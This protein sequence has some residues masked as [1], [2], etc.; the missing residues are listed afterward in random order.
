M[1]IKFTCSK[2]RNSDEL[3][4]LHYTRKMAEDFIGL[5]TGTSP[6][7]LVPPGPES[8]LGKSVCCRAQLEGEIVDAVPEPVPAPPPVDRSQTIALHS[9]ARREGH[10]REHQGAPGDLKDNGQHADYWVLSAEE[11]AK[12]FVRPVRKSYTHVSCGSVTTMATA[13]AETYARDPNFYG[14]T[15]CVSCRDHFPVSE[16]R[17]VGTDEVVGS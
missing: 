3:E 14:A 13:L 5:M 1:L 16:F 9:G 6:M 17:W 8:M 2:C 15:F 11:R 12:G 10:A 4:I 7:Y